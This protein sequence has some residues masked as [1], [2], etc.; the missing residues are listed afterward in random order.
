MHSVACML[1]IFSLE[2]YLFLQVLL[3]TQIYFITSMSGTVHL[4]QKCGNQVPVITLELGL[5]VCLSILYA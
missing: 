1:T 3:Q 5:C 4:T 2:Y